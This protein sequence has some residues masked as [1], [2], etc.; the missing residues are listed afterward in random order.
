[1]RLNIL[2][3]ATRR[4]F[5]EAEMNALGEY[6]AKAIHGKANKITA[7]NAEDLMNYL[8]TNYPGQ[9][10]ERPRETYLGSMQKLYVGLNGETPINY[11]L[12]TGKRVNQK[13]TD[14]GN[15][16]NASFG[17]MKLANDKFNV[18]YSQF[19]INARLARKRYL[20]KLAKEIAQTPADEAVT[21]EEFA[22]GRQRAYDFF[23]RTVKAMDKRGTLTDAQKENLKKHK[24]DIVAELM[25]EG[26]PKRN[27]MRLIDKYRGSDMQ[28]P[29]RVRKGRSAY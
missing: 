21:P 16:F 20:L 12:P 23:I 11:R 25:V 7:E 5:S 28:V 17:L 29:G 15:I 8:E 10:P 27:I 6:Y 14:G 19:N 22:M 13:N 24:A 2:L 26:R 3:E 9:F 4:Q 1:M 18:K